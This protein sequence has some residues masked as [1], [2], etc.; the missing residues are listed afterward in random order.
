MHA[1]SAADTEKMP[2]SNK[3]MSGRKEANREGGWSSR[4]HLEWGTR[5]TVSEPTC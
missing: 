5:P 2:P 4:V 3:S 1:A